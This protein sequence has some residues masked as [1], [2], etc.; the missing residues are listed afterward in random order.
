VEE[1]PAVGEP[2][3]VGS[4]G[5]AAVAGRAAADSLVAEQAHQVLAA[6]ANIGLA[7]D[8][9]EAAVNHRAEVKHI[10]LVAVL[11]HLLAVVAVALVEE[12]ARW[13]LGFVEM[14]TVGV[15]AAVA[16]VS[17]H[18]AGVVVVPEARHLEVRY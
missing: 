6:V 16:G 13:N 5:L 1:L 7:A 4:P 10:A 8:P 2:P 12:L 3:A 15:V 18:L 11:V 9:L 17:G 14:G